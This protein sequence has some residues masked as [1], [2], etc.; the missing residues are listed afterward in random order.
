MADEPS[1]LE[2]ARRLGL[3]VPEARPLWRAASEIAS[4]SGHDAQDVF[5]ELAMRARSTVPGKRDLTSDSIAAPPATALA[6][7]T[8]DALAG[9]PS[10]SFAERLA[11][12]A[13]G[14]GP[15][16]ADGGRI[17]AMDPFDVRNLA[18]EGVAG[19][20]AA[21]PHLDAIQKSFGHHDVGGVRAHVGGAAAKAATGI[22]ARA[23]ATGDDVAFEA[24][25]DI[26]QAAHEAAH[27]VQQRG[28]VRLDG[29]VGRRGDTYEQHADAVAALVVRG[30]SAEALLDTMAHRG[31]AG[32]PAVQREDRD[33][34]GLDD[35]TGEPVV[36]RGPRSRT[37]GQAQ[38]TFEFPERQL[39]PPARLGLVTV[40][41]KVGGEVSAQLTPH[42]SASDQ[43][44]DGDTTTTITQGVTVDSDGGVAYH[45]QIQ[46]EINRRILGFTPS[47][48]GELEV[49]GDSATLGVGGQLQTADQGTV[50]IRTLEAQII[51]AEWDRSESGSG[52]RLVGADLSAAIGIPPF[53]M[54]L[55]P[56]DAQIAPQLELKLELDPNWREIGR[57]LV[58]RIATRA[59]AGAL[60]TGGGAAATDAALAGAGAGLAGPAFAA[61][62]GLAAGYI[63]FR[64]AVAELGSAEAMESVCHEAPKSLYR[65]CLT[66]AATF[67]RVGGF[68]G[69]DGTG[70]R[71]AA[72]AIMRRLAEENNLTED[73]IYEQARAM[74]AREI[75]GQVFE[76]VR[77]SF[78]DQAADRVGSRIRFGT[79][80][81]EALAPAC[82][83][84][85]VF[86]R[87]G[88]AHGLPTYGHVAEP[89]ES[90]QPSSGQ[91]PQRLARQPGS[92][93]LS[94]A[95]AAA[96][97]GRGLDGAAG[98]LP[99]AD[100]IASA[101]G[102]HDVS[103]VRVAV[104]G[105]A[106]DASASLGA[107]A[108]AMGDAI[109]F[110]ASPD[111][112]TVAHEAA[113]VVQQ[114][115]GVQVR[116]G[117]GQPGDQ[118]ERHADA[119]AD[120][121]VRG[122]S[123]E[124]V[125][126]AMTGGGAAHEPAVQRLEHPPRQDG[127]PAEL[128][129]RF[130]QSL[131]QDLSNVRLHTDSAAAR[132]ADELAAQ[133]FALGEDIYFAEGTYDP[134]SDEGRALIAHE[135][136]HVAQQRQGQLGAQTKPAV[137]SPGDAAEQQADAVAPDLLAGRPV[138]VAA[139]PGGVAYRDTETDRGRNL[140]RTAIDHADDAQLGQI[141]AAIDEAT[142]HSSTA[143]V[144]R[145]SLPDGQRVALTGEDAASLRSLAAGRMTMVGPPLSGRGS[146]SAP[147][148]SPGE[149]AATPEAAGDGYGEAADQL[150]SAALHGDPN[151]A[152]ISAA[153]EASETGG[154][155]RASDAPTSAAEP[156]SLGRSQQLVKEQV[157]RVRHYLAGTDGSGHPIAADRR[158]A[159]ERVRNALAES[160]LTAPM[161]E[162]ID[163]R[164]R[165]A[166][167][168]AGV[169]SME[170]P[171]QITDRRSRD[172]VRRSVDQYMSELADAIGAEAAADVRREALAGHP[173]AVV[174]AHGAEFVDSI[175]GNRPEGSR[176]VVEAGDLNRMHASGTYPR[177]FQEFRE[178]WRSY[179]RTHR[180]QYRQLVRDGASAEA[181]TRQIVDAPEQPAEMN[182]VVEVLRANREVELGSMEGMCGRENRGRYI[183]GDQLVAIYRAR[184]GAE[185][186]ALTA[187][188]CGDSREENEI[189]APNI[190]QLLRRR[191]AREDRTAWYT[192]GAM[193]SPHWPTFDAALPEIDRFT[194]TERDIS[195]LERAADVAPRLL[196]GYSG[197]EASR[198]LLRGQLA[199]I[200]HGAPGDFSNWF[201][202][203]T[204]QVR[205]LEDYRELLASF[206]GGG[207]SASNRGAGVFA[208]T[209]H[210]IHQG[211]HYSE[212]SQDADA[213]GAAPGGEQ[214]AEPEAEPAGFRVTIDTFFPQR[215][216]D[217]I[218][219]LV[220]RDVGA[221]RERAARAEARAAA[222][223]ARRARPRR[224]AH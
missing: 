119:V 49:S 57:R 193:A 174:A 52:L 91:A 156:A 43:P 217:Q 47:L 130:E 50:G 176:Q 179:A 202:G 141:V 38:F 25:P 65:Y 7:L 147:A 186:A 201:L 221:D 206:F 60:A 218:M 79:L 129:E 117:I 40:T 175:E 31:A 101:F 180:A 67:F 178:N 54:R 222:R 144:C 85:G 139:A 169:M 58:Q 86:R 146:A 137:S 18:Q 219:A 132:A 148:P 80:I 145:L 210:Y 88:G 11:R 102:R 53:Q 215:Q 62:L 170:D 159:Y 109:A 128:L 142:R 120:L 136:A 63:T 223:A 131:E 92:S 71:N 46:T 28:G 74:G 64:M 44:Q 29:G 5:I 121:V 3:S 84:G 34:D 209:R 158:E 61:A 164:G 149:S 126:D 134:S 173:D 56:H 161:V 48:V 151:A 66:Y 166:E 36:G 182:E 138:R 199:R 165:R 187:P 26:R 135:V 214:A 24:S 10:S 90:S 114:R 14:A 191:I 133:A 105:A 55:G 125:L 112:R 181:A 183:G 6:T 97:A 124:Q 204:P 118:Y 82:W 143:H 216:E 155:Y 113:H 205:T 189:G 188:H 167:A 16:Q 22:G 41:A 100:R 127:L 195:N 106:A 1:L 171:D 197:S 76:V 51:L 99:F 98:A 213:E 95:E 35:A 39:G 104:G 70:G 42:R 8:A 192:R 162:D 72:R 4:Q 15:V 32:G 220:A 115:H 21:L 163:R 12:A 9:S 27:V 185:E 110:E 73:Q 93:V 17:A 111:L 116:D 154:R 45:P 75:Y 78:R 89:A 224:G 172:A 196:E 153:N 198:S 13:A 20:G 160:G 190:E 203:D 87:E 150:E 23:Y 208:F 194:S 140:T 212:G 108:Y 107:H 69:R 33:G 184:H 122:E 68:S 2:L 37:Q 30:E 157:S 94:A 200:N 123:A 152:A 177:G 59:G 207:R 96:I 81:N 83:G 211:Q 103:G 77:P 168:W 19:A